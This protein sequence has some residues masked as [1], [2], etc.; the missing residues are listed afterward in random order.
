MT[1]TVSR[2]TM[3][4][5]TLPESWTISVLDEVAEVITGNTPS[6]RDKSNYGHDMP[7]VKPGEL[8]DRPVAKAEDNLSEKGAKLARILP[9]TAVLVSCIGNLG[10]T[11]ISQVPVAFNQQINAAVF[12]EAVIPKF[13]FY[14]LQ[15]GEVRNWMEKHASATT[16]TILNKGK[17]SKLPFPIAPFNEQRRIVEKIEELFT[18]LDAGVRSLEQTRALL[19]SYRR[20]VLKAAVEGEL[21]REWREAHREELEPASEL[22]ERILQERRENFAGKKYKE[23]ASPDTSE[24]PELPEGWAWMKTDQLFN[25]VTSG[26]RGWAKYYADEGA[27]FLRIGNL[28]HDSIRLD[29][30]SL[31]K[32]QPPEGA[33]GTR[34]RVISDDVLISITADIGMVA[35]IPP[36]FEEAY[37]NQHIALARPSHRMNINYLAWCLVSEP[38]NKQLTGRQYGATKPGLNLDDIRA[39]D[40]PVPPLEEQHSIVEEIERRLSVVDKLEATVEENLKQAS[41]L[42]QS[43]LKQAFCGELVAQDPDN[44]PA[45]V[46]L[47]RIREERQAAKQKAGKKIIRARRKVAAGDWSSELFPEQGG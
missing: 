29:L 18:K 37:I 34:T 43:I 14:Y 10:K 31:Q 1:D 22:L 6:K 13:G 32:V 36:D 27:L 26:S 40:I 9:P 30:R 39:V 25:F 4:N 3:D 38:G 23:P 5:E 44:E 11:A 7:L 21:S 20:S 8:L 2:Q 41:G 19:K 12:S 45:G 15:T 17:F 33:E 16:V 24:L 46:L 28:D 47:E 35:V 42:R